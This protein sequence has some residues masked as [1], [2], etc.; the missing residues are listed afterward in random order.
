MYENILQGKNSNYIMCIH[1]YIYVNIGNG[2][3]QV[4]ASVTPS[5]TEQDQSSGRRNI[6]RYMY[7]TNHTYNTNYGYW[8]YSVFIRTKTEMEG[9]LWFDISR[10]EGRDNIT[11]HKH[12]IS[13][14][15]VLSMLGIPSLHPI[16]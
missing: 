16:F 9:S 8:V 3:N 12:P 6:Y 5:V 14:A 10:A 11:N 15:K 4:L 13:K 7:N 2:Q 1:I